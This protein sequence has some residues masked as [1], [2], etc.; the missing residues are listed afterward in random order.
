MNN[1]SLSDVSSAIF[2]DIVLI[3]ESRA[4]ILNLTNF[5][6]MNT[7]ANALLA[8][9]ASPIM[10]HAPEE[11][12]ELTTISR[13]LVL[14][15]GTLD[16][17]WIKNIFLAAEFAFAKNKPVVFD[18]VGAGASQLRTQTALDLLKTG[19]ITVLRGNASEIIAL[20]QKTKTKGVDA[21]EKS[22]QA[23]TSAKNISM[24]FGCVVVISGEMDY[25][26]FKNT[27]RAVLNGSPMMSRVT[28]MGCTATALIGAFLAV[29]SNPLLAS[30]H[31][32]CCMGIC[33]ELAAAQ[34]SGPG[35]F[36]PQFLDVLYSTDLN[37]ISRFLK[38]SSE[39]N[40]DE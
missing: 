6:V 33:G 23:L 3:R 13:A 31:A 2:S 7:T 29:N 35:T 25:C 32:M 40:Q 1:S 21:T 28:G 14:N 39:V 37:R 15:I 36:F 18:P 34:S 20:D 30:F 5:V 24:Q 17:F 4:L 9:G 19:Y 16:A 10:A 26:V 22:E 27:S 38:I 11:L 8:I 12:A